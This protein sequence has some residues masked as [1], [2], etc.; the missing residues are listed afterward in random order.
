MHFYKSLLMATIF[1]TSLCYSFGYTAEH[2]AID[3]SYLLKSCKVVDNKIYLNPG[4]VYVAPEEILVN[5]EGQ[6][7][8]VGSIGSDTEGVYVTAEEMASSAKGGTWKCRWC[9]R[10]NVIEDRWCAL[11]GRGWGALTP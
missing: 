7:V 6:M 9:N 5:I 11:C 1:F 4:M 10:V 3:V 2:D 8:S